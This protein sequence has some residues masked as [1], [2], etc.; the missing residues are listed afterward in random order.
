[1]GFWDSLYSTLWMD[2]LLS[3]VHKYQYRPLWNYGF[4][5]SSAWLSIVPTM[6]I[7]TGIGSAFRNQ[8]NTCQQGLF[9]AACCII[10]YISAILYLFLTIPIFSIGKASYTLGLAPCYAVLSA[11]GF[12]MLTR[13]PLARAT[14]NGIIACWAVSIYLA[15]F[16]F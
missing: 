10:V 8:R 5:L 13:R 16:V 2:G 15:Y 7:L 3:G 9:F 6:A 12:E 11:G 14:I 1:M 4:L